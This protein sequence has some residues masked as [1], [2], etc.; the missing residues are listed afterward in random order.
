M[1]QKLWEASKKNKK[2]SNLYKY[3]KFITKKYKL[4]FKQNYSKILNWS[5][6]NPNKFW[7][8]I[9]DFS[10]IDG[11]KNEKLFKSKTFFK[12]SDS[13]LD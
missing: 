11:I 5:I 3:E 13:F 4:K 10:D 8:S 6:K 7:S 12:K 1:R 2:L 9:W